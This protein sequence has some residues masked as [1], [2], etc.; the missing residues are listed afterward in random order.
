MVK[1]IT[2]LVFRFCKICPPLLMPLF[3]FFGFRAYAKVKRE[4]GD[5]MILGC[6]K[7]STGDM[8]FMGL[9]LARWLSKNHISNYIC[10]YGANAQL[11]IANLFPAL[12]K[13]MYSISAKNYLF[14]EGLRRIQPWIEYKNFF[15]ATPVNGLFKLKEGLTDTAASPLQGYRNLTML[16]GYL[17]EMDLPRDCPPDLPVFGEPESDPPQDTILLSPYSLSYRDYQQGDAFWDSIV[18]TLAARGYHLLTNCADHEQALPNTEKLFLPYAISVPYLNKCAGFIGVRSGLCDIISSSRCKKV[19]I[20]S[21]EAMYNPDGVN[22][23]FTGLK[24]LGLCDDAIELEL[25]EG[26]RNMESVINRVLAQFPQ[27][28]RVL[29]E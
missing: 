9:Y 21:Y 16:D 3:M 10:F 12:R 1:R 27:H 5:K 7:E 22:L 24:N 17:W 26:N 20:Y 2:R 15:F 13:R 4:A 29:R 23:A 19:I 6:A 8:Y 18:H 28:T 11:S 25:T 14:W